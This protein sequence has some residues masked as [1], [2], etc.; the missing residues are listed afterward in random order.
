MTIFLMI[1]VAVDETSNIWKFSPN[2]L[3]FFSF[4]NTSTTLTNLIKL[5]PEKS[6]IFDQ[7]TAYLYNYENYT[8]PQGLNNCQYLLVSIIVHDFNEWNF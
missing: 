8:D 7:I 3:S 2:T 1:Q 4:E 5:Q 6:Q